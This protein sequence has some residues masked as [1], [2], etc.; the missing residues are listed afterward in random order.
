[1]DE[2]SSEILSRPEFQKPM[3]RNNRSLKDYDPDNEYAAWAWGEAQKESETDWYETEEGFLYD[4]EH[5]KKKLYE[6]EKTK[7]L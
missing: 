6:T 7:N 5:E 1:V 4:E 2:V 3:Y